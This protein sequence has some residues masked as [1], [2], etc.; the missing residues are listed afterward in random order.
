[1]T[2]WTLAFGATTAFLYF[3]GLHTVWWYNADFS[4][5]LQQ[6]YAIAHGNVFLHH[7]LIPADSFLLEYLLFF[8]LLVAIM[9][10]HVT[11][12]HLVSAM[13][14]A[15]MTLLAANLALRGVTG[16][17][18]WL[19]ASFVMV[20]LALP[21]GQL[22]SQLALAYG[23]GA[24]IVWSLLALT[25][26][27]NSPRPLARA[28]AT[29]A[30]A[31]AI[32]GDTLVLAYAV[33]PL[34]FVGVLWTPGD[35]RRRL[36]SPFASAALLSLGIAE[37]LHVLMVS[38]GTYSVAGTTALATRASLVVS[39]HSLAPNL[40][41]LFTQNGYTPESVP[42]VVVG[43]ALLF[44]VALAGFVT[45]G[46]SMLRDLGPVLRG[47][48]PTPRSSDL[49]RYVLFLGAI[50]AVATYFLLFDFGSSQRYL[51]FTDVVMV[52]LGAHWLG[53]ARW[54]R[55]SLIS[56]VVSVALVGGTIGAA[57]GATQILRQPL[58]TN[59]YQ[60]VITFLEQRHLRLGLSDYWSSS[61]ITAY[62]GGRVVV[63]AVAPLRHGLQP[64]I[65]AG[66]TRWYDTTFSFLACP[67]NEYVNYNLE[68]NGPTLCVDP[69]F[70]YAR[71]S[72]VYRVGVYLI[73]VFSHPMPFFPP[74][75]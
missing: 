66:D 17:T 39:L 64:F 21:G 47:D 48:A 63:R 11:V 15:G 72:H 60:R 50:G 37:A 30:L 3:Y 41:D 68:L 18:R 65:Q 16:R 8:G 34:L 4:D 42:L 36:R 24:T 74:R 51:D 71:V 6:G 67:I 62:S 56:L 14:W 57:S 75:H 19:S 26:L 61:T 58:P 59:P 29:L 43:R 53:T 40:I 49:V 33:L 10:L 45:T 7:W 46:V 5:G 1:V 28:G 44:G 55:D 20:S 38:V 70:P 25:L 31:V 2:R 12:L 54:R 27:A 32:T 35:W 9:G 23:H 13:T 22:L 52:V 73:A 69:N